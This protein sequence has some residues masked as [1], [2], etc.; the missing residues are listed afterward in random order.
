MHVDL[1]GLIYVALAVAWIGY[2]VPRALKSHES[3]VQ[4]RPIDAASDSQRVL[5]RTSP[6]TK[7]V[8]AEKQAAP[9]VRTSSTGGARRRRR[10]L[11]GLLFVAAVVGGLVGFAVIPRW[12]LAIPLVLVLGWLVLCRLMV[13]RTPVSVGRPVVADVEED[14]PVA[15]TPAPA[16]VVTTRP[17]APAPVEPIVDEDDGSLWDPLPLTLPTYVSKPAARRTVRAIDL[18]QPGVTS[19][20]HQAADS[21]LARRVQ[22]ERAKADDVAEAPA[23]TDQQSA[24]RVAGA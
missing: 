9:V 12:T 20:G 18:T 2:M 24:R 21:A 5:S 23:E 8:L 14:A 1:S 16:R 7:A 19:S 6:T 15:V 13:R 4:D 11:L 17:T 10:V 3:A 22:A